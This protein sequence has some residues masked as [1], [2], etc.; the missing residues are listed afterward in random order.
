MM[1]VP[2]EEVDE[3]LQNVEA[4]LRIAAFDQEEKRLK[5][6]NTQRSYILPKLPQGNYIFCDFQT[7]SLPGIE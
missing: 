5:Q 2:K 6:R 4:D 3:L 7:P 1:G